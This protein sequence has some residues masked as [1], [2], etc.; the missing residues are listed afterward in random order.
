MQN[1]SEHASAAREIR[2]VLVDDHALFRSGLHDLLEQHGVDVAGEVDDGTSA[3]EVVRD[4]APD[5]VLMDVNM[6]GISGI[7]ATMRIR[8]VAPTAQVIMLT[9]SA[10]EQDVEDSICAGACGYVL[11]D[12]PVDQI[13]A[14][15][16]E[17][18]AGESHLSPRIAANILEHVRASPSRPTLPE[19]GRAELTER[20]T[21]VL[22]LMAE[23]K[24]NAQIAEELFI[25]VQTVKNHVSNILAKLEV[26]NRVQAAVQAVQSRLISTKRHPLS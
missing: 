12:A 13:L 26:E 11:K 21:E 25:S 9:V 8:A 6:P 20:E 16:R 15:I 4:A 19:E 3:V 2:V 7:E 1:A 17:A 22:R 14:A 10:D 18:V 24:E 23:G 5:V